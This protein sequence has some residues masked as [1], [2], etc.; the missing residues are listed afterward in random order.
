MKSFSDPRTHFRVV[1]SDTPVSVDGFKL[2]EPTGQ[3][4]CEECGASHLNIDEIPH[5]AD[6]SQRFVKSAWWQDT[7]AND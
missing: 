1:R 5:K 2:G 7:A 6:C 3:I 4:E